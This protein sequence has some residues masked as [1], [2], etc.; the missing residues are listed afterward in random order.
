MTIGE[1]EDRINRLANDFTRAA[2]RLEDEFDGGR[3]MDDSYDEAQR[4]LNLGQ[5]LENALSRSR[6]GG[7]AQNEW[8]SIRQ[9]LNTIANAYGYNNRNRR[10][11]NVQLARH[12]VPSSKNVW[13]LTRLR[14]PDLPN[15]E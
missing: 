6:L 2:E 3:N 12:S 4:V 13:N 9:D 5:Q 11:G 15:P 10:G 7:S 14:F 1:R 8:N